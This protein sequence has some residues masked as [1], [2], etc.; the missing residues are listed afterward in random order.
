MLFALSL[1]FL[2]CNKNAY[3]FSRLDG[4]DAEG[5]WGFPLANAKYT[6]EDILDMSNGWEYIQTDED[7]VLKLNYVVQKDTILEA[8]A[9]LNCM[10][11]KH[12]DYDGSWSINTGGIAV[13]HGLSVDVFHD[14]VE[15]S[16]PSENIIF[17]SAIVKGGALTVQFESTLPMLIEVKC[18]DIT[19]AQSECLSGNFVC[20][21][22]QASQ[23][24]DLSHYKIEP[25]NGSN[26]LRFAVK[27]NAQLPEGQLPDITQLAFHFHMHSLSFQEIKGQLSPLSSAIEEN[28]PMDL[29]FLSKYAQGSVTMF[30]PQ[31]KLEIN[32][33][34][35][36]R[37]QL[38]LEKAGLTH[39]GVLVSSF[40][41]P[42][43]VAIDVPSSTNGYQAVDIPEM[44][45]LQLNTAIDNV[46][47]KGRVEI[48]PNRRK[49]PSV[50][51][52]EGQKIGC[53]MSFEIPLHIQM[54]QLSFKDT[55]PLKNMDLP[56]VQGAKNMVVR[57]LI[58]NTLPVNVKMQL[59]FY[60]DN[61]HEVVDSLFSVKQWLR[62]SFDGNPILS[63]F[64]IEK[65][66]WATI[67][68]MLNCGN[69]ILDA[70]A[71]TD[72][73]K[74]SIRSTQGLRMRMSAKFDLNVG[75]LVESF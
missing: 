11:D 28:L 7:N 58:E 44:S 65:K 53:R 63:E 21:N 49:A 17:E 59:Y 20:E 51:I 62:G 14:T 2:S 67:Q 47:L 29:S 8:D 12:I 30:H 6:I 1:L 68:R 15:V 16:L 38:V 54:N 4:F 10:A 36:V 70:Q 41:Q 72:D 48:N 74:V 23:D 73:E 25:Y 40:F 32:N 66:D 46:C 69:I 24:L 37:C 22:G 60:D 27:V 61:R 3:D 75:E 35:P 71:D 34:L 42:M 18:L 50:V 45:P 5:T 26:K 55:L 57:M 64:Y 39:D 43:P 9:I 31:L 52:R 56:D 19:N 13:G 33:E